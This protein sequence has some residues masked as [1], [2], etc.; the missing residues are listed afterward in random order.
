MICSGILLTV[1]KMTEVEM[2]DFE[3]LPGEIKRHIKETL[4]KE[5]EYRDNTVLG[6]YLPE[7]F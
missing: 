3:F 1:I 5:Y 4:G 6:I 7:G 2:T